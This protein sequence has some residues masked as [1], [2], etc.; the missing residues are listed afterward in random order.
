MDKLD[1]DLIFAS[2][3]SSVHFAL[4]CL[5]PYG[6]HLRLKSSFVTPEGE[7]VHW[8]EF[9]DLEGPGWASNTVGG[10]L[11]LYRWGRFLKDAKIQEWA[12]QLLDHI[13]EDGFI[14]DSTGFIHPY[15]D[16]ADK[17]FC[18]NYQHNNRWLCP[19]SLAKIGTQLIEF[20]GELGTNTRANKMYHVASDL[21][22]WLD[23]RI[24]PLPNGWLPRRVDG[25]GKGYPWTPEGGND[26]I[27]SASADGLYLLQLWTLLST[28]SLADYRSR[29]I[30]LGNSYIQSGGYFGSINHDTYDFHESV[31]YA[32]AFRILLQSGTALSMPEWVDFAYS[33]ALAGLGIFQMVNDRNGL[34]TKNLLWMEKSWNTA[35][36]WENAEASTAMLEAWIDRGDRLNLIRGNDILKAIALHH[37]GN[38]GFL[39]E[40]VDWDNRVSRRHHINHELYEDIRYTEPLLNN[41]H[42]VEPT[43]LLLERMNYQTEKFKRY[44]DSITLVSTHSAGSRPKPQ[45]SEGARYFIRF[46]YPAISSDQRVIES[47]EFARNANAEGVLLFEASYD[48][49]PAILTIDELEPR[50]N[51]IKAIVPKFREVVKEVHINVMITLGHVDAG[52]ARPE[53]LPFD[54]MVDESGHQSRST[55]CPLDPEFRNHVAELYRMAAE[56]GADVIW[57]D[58]DLR[59]L[60]HDL[61]DYTCFC[62]LHLEQ[63]RTRTGVNWTR[64]Q[65]VTALRDDSSEPDLR[66]HWFDLQEE[67]ILSLLT[68][69]EQVVH[70]VNP[71]QSIGLMSVGQNF[72][73][74]E[75]RRTDRLL[76]KL[77]GI[78]HQPRLR[79]GSGFWSD[80]RPSALF[81]KVHACSREIDFLGRDV[82]II[83]EIENHPY[84]PFGKSQRLLALELVLNVLYGLTDISLNLLSSMA[85]KNKIEPEGSNYASFLAKMKPF[86]DSL[87][88]ECAGKKRAGV[89]VSDHPDYSRKA[90]LRGKNLTEWIQRRPWESLL[91]RSGIPLGNVDCAP[92]L[93]VGDVIR[94]LSDY[95]L[96]WYLREGVILDP[97]AAQNMIERGWGD[98]LGLYD[99]APVNDAV[100]ELILNDRI[101]DDFDGYLLPAYNLTGP[102]KLF[103]Y[104]VKPES[105]TIL[106]RWINVDGIDRG[107]ALVLLT[108]D[109]KLFSADFQWKAGLLPYHLEGPI[110]AILN[111]PRQ[112]LWMKMLEF[113]SGNPLPCTIANGVNLYPILSI[114]EDQER[115]VLAVINLS[116]DDVHDI[117]VD[118]PVLSGKS[119]T[120]EILNP[121]GRWAP[122]DSPISNW[123]ELDAGYF[124]ATVVRLVTWNKQF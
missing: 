124:S 1:L 27:Y 12:L 15:Y 35:Y 122:C 20:A 50:F 96:I 60:I 72:H 2:A 59:Y 39:T 119:C 47:L 84:T 108:K 37:H 88:K 81:D 78:H 19:G 45:G 8:H 104:H 73:A 11:L 118:I 100:N 18:L 103:T 53:R 110:P 115:M 9:G 5:E 52:S 82:K 94:S 31:A 40:G 90:H 23:Q 51:R 64:E 30:A 117:Q 120:V 113:V 44:E 22:Q 116:A 86:L 79:P 91:A 56:C 77:A 14:Q 38:F 7:P 98:K 29:I 32:T 42:L 107:P 4:S 95:E 101:T 92:H 106:T 6:E 10:A 67:T 55:C 80:E 3:Q 57:V 71:D 17:R 114:S 41:L 74:A 111:H 123:L 16:I 62:D 105:S 54:Y 24:Q 63:M 87:A 76:R 65:L 34:P 97:L 28:K 66:Q 36:L 75:G 121:D 61:S 43:L 112:V 102:E 25:E 70:S 58:D 21:G 83:A 48:M 68:M 46:Y 85:G 93:L 109:E 49:D 26:P 33:K 69:I 13:L 89:G 99:V